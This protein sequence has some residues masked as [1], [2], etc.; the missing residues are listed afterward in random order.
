L[1]FPF[2][3]FVDTLIT[4]SQSQLHDVFTRTYG[5]LY[6][7]NSALFGNYFERIR[8]Y[9]QSGAGGNL[10]E[11]TMTFFTELYEKMFQVN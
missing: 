1:S 9:Y 3:D 8:S 2:P 11:V 7:R 4:D 5:V 10:Q 6:E